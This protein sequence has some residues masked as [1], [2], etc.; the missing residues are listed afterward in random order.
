MVQKMLCLSATKDG[1]KLMKRCIPEK[2]GTK[3]HGK[4][5]ERIQ[6]LEVKGSLPRKRE[7]GKSKDR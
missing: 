2:A 6:V 5:L 4:M 3:E 1:T 7:T